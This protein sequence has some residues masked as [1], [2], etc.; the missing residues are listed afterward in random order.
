MSAPYRFSEVWRIRASRDRVFAVL[1]DLER[2]PLWWP[3]V[4]SIAAIDESSAL[5]TIRSAL[6]VSLRIV[7]VRAIDDDARMVLE[8]HLAG[9]LEGW[10]RWTLHA[11]AN[12]TVARFE[13]SALLCKAIPRGIDTLVRP[14]FR[15]NHSFMMR[16]GER[17]IHTYLSQIGTSAKRS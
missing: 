6:P 15:A 8:A 13:E 5:V 16:S 14:I 17:G 9:D 1:R 10:S 7:T 4:R 2:Y 11:V 12:G 3:Q